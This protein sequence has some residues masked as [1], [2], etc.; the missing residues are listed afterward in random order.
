MIN[1]AEIQ[2]PY[3]LGGHGVGGGLKLTLNFVL[4]QICYMILFSTRKA[5][6]GV[7]ILSYFVIIY[8][9][10]RNYLLITHENVFSSLGKCKC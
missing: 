3:P 2:R 4:Q 1:R 8:T 6:S 10:D 5:Y 7:K 9:P